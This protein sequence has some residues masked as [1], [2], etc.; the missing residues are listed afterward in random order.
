MKIYNKLN[1]LNNSKSVCLLTHINP[2]ADALCSAVVLREFIKTYFNITTVDIFAECSSIPNNYLEILG[3]VKLNKKPKTYN[4]A[5][6]MDCPNSDRLGIYKTL[7]EKSKNKI[8]IDHHA[9][10]NNS[11]DINIVE[12]VS[13]TCE[14]IYKILKHFKFKISEENQGKLYAGIITDTNNFSVGN[15]TSTTF[16][17][18]SEVNN[19]INRENIYNNFLANNSLKNMQLLSLAIQNIVSFDHGQIIISHI[20]H[21]EAKKFKTSFDDYYGIINKLATISSAKFICFI[22]PK[23]NIYYVGMRARKGANVATIAKLNGGGGHNGAAAFTSELSLRE[24]EET[25]L[26]AFREELSKTSILNN[27]LF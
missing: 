23:D 15:I 8:I 27:K 3:K 19:S 17:I 2:D 24:I 12:N 21:E 11:G 22:K 20:S 13:S 7:F 26:T 9:T 25:V 4:T 18:A 1:I 6:M 5:I 10:N 16:K 14:I